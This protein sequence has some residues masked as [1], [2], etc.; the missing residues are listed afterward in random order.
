MS[1]TQYCIRLF[2]VEVLSPSSHIFSLCTNPAAAR[3]APKHRNAI[4]LSVT[5][6]NFVLIVLNLAYPG[7]ND[8]IS[9]TELDS[10]PFPAFAL[11]AGGS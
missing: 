10:L 3:A 1:A 2:K 7:A 4:E 11:V 5:D 8:H 9:Q 6:L